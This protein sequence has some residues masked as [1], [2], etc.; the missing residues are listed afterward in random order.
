MSIKRYSGKLVEWSNNLKKQKIGKP[1]KP[2]GTEARIKQ[3]LA[4][5]SH[6]FRKPPVP[7]VPLLVICC[8]G[9]PEPLSSSWRLRHI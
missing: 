9:L 2:C 3:Q 1:D 7:A 6:Y 8:P 5:K 4:V